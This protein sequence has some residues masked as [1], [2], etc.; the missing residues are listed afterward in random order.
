[1]MTKRYGPWVALLVF[2]ACGGGDAPDP[3][4]EAAPATTP[5]PAPETAMPAPPTGPLTMPEWYAVDHDARTVHLTVTAGSTPDNNHWNFNGKIRGASAIVV[6]EGYAVT[7]ELVN[8]DPLMAH[9]LGIQ[10]GFTNPMVPPTPDPAFDGAMTPNPQ[11]VAEST[12][13]GQSATIEFVATTAGNYAMVCYV[14]GHAALGMWLYF[15]V[16]ADGGAGVRGA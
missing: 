1:M 2:A 12:L 5:A 10:A 7:I 6:P 4:P 16:S 8:R 9:S 3:A 11:S 14:P 13:P 15:D